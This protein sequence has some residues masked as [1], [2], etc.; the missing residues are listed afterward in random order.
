MTLA[1]QAIGACL[2]SALIMKW[3]M[4]RAL[5]IYPPSHQPLTPVDVLGEKQ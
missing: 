3:G 1:M 4:D 5:D 2:L